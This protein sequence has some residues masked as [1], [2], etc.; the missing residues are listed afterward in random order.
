MET[1][2]Y[3]IGKVYSSQYTEIR[4]VFLRAISLAMTSSRAVKGTTNATVVIKVTQ[5]SKVTV[6]IMCTEVIVV[7]T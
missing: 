4:Q 3:Q 1:R 5:A 7:K 6:S 2:Y